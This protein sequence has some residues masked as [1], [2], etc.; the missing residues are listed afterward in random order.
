MSYQEFRHWQ[1]WCDHEG[2]MQSLSV[3]EYHQV[4]PA[5]NEEGWYSPVGGNGGFGTVYC[6]EHAVLYFPECGECFKRLRPKSRGKDEFPGTVA[7]GVGGLCVTC[8]ERKNRGEGSFSMELDKAV[9]EYKKFRPVQLR[10][11]LARSDAEGIR[12][13]QELA[14]AT[15]TRHGAD[16]LREV[17]ALG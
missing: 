12:E 8:T 13:I 15:L 11:L 16:D 2:C 17:L 14:S 1:V 10:E 7:R 4:G 3:L 9:A 6:N 5:I